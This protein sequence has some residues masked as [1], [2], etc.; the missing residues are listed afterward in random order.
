MLTKAEIKA[1][2]ENYRNHLIVYSYGK[3]I[4]NNVTYDTNLQANRARVNDFI[5]EEDTNEDGY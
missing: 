3:F 4:Y 2:S 5:N 1:V